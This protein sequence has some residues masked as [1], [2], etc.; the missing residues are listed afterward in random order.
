MK[1]SSDLYGIELK[2]DVNKSVE[3]CD[4]DCAGKSILL[5][6]SN[7]IE[8]LQLFSH[9]YGTIVR[10][11]CMFAGVGK[12]FIRVVSGDFFSTL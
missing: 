9:A 11:S 7:E 6:I 2:R 12:I 4:V 10:T 5:N 3:R 8:R 1:S